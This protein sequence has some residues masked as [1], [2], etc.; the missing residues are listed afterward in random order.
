MFISVHKCVQDNLC[1]MIRRFSIVS[2]FKIIRFKISRFQEFQ[3]FKGEDSESGGWKDD[4]GC[5]YT[6]RPSCRRCPRCRRRRRPPR[7]PR[8]RHRHHQCRCPPRL[9]SLLMVQPLPFFLFLVFDGRV[10][11]CS[12]IVS[13]HDAALPVKDCVA[14]S[15]ALVW[16]LRFARAGPAS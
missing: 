5:C 14:W 1:F 8:C 12:D 10:G 6:C 13:P 3:D 7:R 4:V 2:M 11:R 15:E 16:L 9:T